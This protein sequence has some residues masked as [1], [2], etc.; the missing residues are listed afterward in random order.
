M[1]LAT[2]PGVDDEAP[3]GDP[4]H[5]LSVT[6]RGIGKRTP[7][8][9]YS[10]QGRGG[11][12]N[13]TTSRLSDATGQLAGALVA[14]YDAELLLVTDLGTVIRIPVADV[15]VSGRA[16]RG[17]WLMRAD[18]EATVV[19]VALVLDDEDEDAEPDGAADGAIVVDGP[20]ADDAA[21]LDAGGDEPADDAD[22]PASG[23]D[24]G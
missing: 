21:V 9:E 7:I 18:Q 15:K 20:P 3:T 10:V 4:V 2:V 24:E 6:E 11:F 17:V 22:T 5:L 1:G 16:T 13:R 8:E 12:G 19:G 23:G 14:P